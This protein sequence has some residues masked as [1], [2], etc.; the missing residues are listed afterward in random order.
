MTEGTTAAHGTAGAPPPPASAAAARALVRQVLADPPVPLSRTAANDM[1]LVTS[2][3]VTNAFR[4]GGGLT[5]FRV[6]PEA[7][8]LR[9]A[10]T[11]R[12]P[13]PPV[14]RAPGDGPRGRP[15]GFGWPL[16][17]R[18][19]RS[20]TITPAPAGKTIEAVVA[21]GTAAG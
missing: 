13:T 4:H 7:H 15:G 16:V 12:S 1:L 10:V 11:D 3:L 8:G 6:T 20:V 5:A 19:S 21:Y 14:A 18:L 17:Q 2:E 9:I